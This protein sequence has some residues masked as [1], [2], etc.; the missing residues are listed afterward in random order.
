MIEK[1]VDVELMIKDILNNPDS[2]Y[3]VFLSIELYD[4]Y[5]KRPAEEMHLSFDNWR[6]LYELREEKEKAIVVNKRLYC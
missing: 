6:R 4:R 1:N 2:P 5:D 3:S